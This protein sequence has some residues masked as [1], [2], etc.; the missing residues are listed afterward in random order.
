MGNARTKLNVA[1]F[2]GCLFVAAVFGLIAQSWVS[3]E[4]YGSGRGP[5]CGRGA[6]R[7]NKGRKRQQGDGLDGGFE[8]DRHQ[9][10]RNPAQPGTRPPATRG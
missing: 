9:H 8:R 1:Y 2:N 7:P 5:A 3:P 4:K 10:Q 6:G